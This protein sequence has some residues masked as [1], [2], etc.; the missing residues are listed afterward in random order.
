MEL[1]REA[2]ESNTALTSQLPSGEAHPPW[3]NVFHGQRLDSRCAFAAGAAQEAGVVAS[4]DQG[5]SEV[6]GLGTPFAML[7]AHATS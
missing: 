4:D 7:T 5:L 1:N 3:L 2:P 6:M